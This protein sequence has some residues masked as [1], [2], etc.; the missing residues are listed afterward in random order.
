MSIEQEL[1]TTAEVARRKSNIPHNSV[2]QELERGCLKHGTE[3]RSISGAGTGSLVSRI[4][5]RL[6][7]LLH[8]KRHILPTIY[9]V[10]NLLVDVNNLL[11]ENSLRSIEIVAASAEAAKQADEIIGLRGS[12]L[13]LTQQVSQKASGA[14]TNSSTS[15]SNNSDTPLSP[16][17]DRYYRAFEDRFRGTESAIIAKQSNYISTIRP[18]LPKPAFAVDIGCGR[19][20]WLKILA[21]E[22]LQV[23]G[24]DMN[25]AMIA[26]AKA[27]GINAV[28]SD[29][30]SW[31]GKQA[32]ASVDLIT[33]FH[34]VEHLTPN[35]LLHILAEVARVLKKNG[36]VL[37]ETPN[38]E[39]IIV[40]ACNFW[41]DITHKRPIPPPTLAFI[42]E[43]LGL[44]QVECIRSGI[45]FAGADPQ[46]PL[47]APQDYAIIA[48]KR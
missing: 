6:R 12:I 32:S 28:H 48:K 26:E 37:I 40:G 5:G 43:F 44:D 24:I 9:N 11:A 25:L 45:P 15:S 31:L 46:N 22:G 4:S 13:H 39:N 38:P 2:A 1:A 17:W 30:L 20:E 19:C 29:A 21:A 23:L 34:V 42:L 8:I 18:L 47:E 10:Q 41:T 14:T 7:T 3:A 16:L 35:D 36:L 27:A 33:S